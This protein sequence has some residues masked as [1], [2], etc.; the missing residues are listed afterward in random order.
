LPNFIFLI[1]RLI[2]TFIDLEGFKSLPY[3]YTAETLPQKYHKY[4]GDLS[5]LSNLKVLINQYESDEIYSIWNYY[6]H[7]FLQD[8]PG[9]LGL[10]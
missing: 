10:E 8:N 6:R 2:P 9:I 4:A 5:A 1:E 3:Q 7:K